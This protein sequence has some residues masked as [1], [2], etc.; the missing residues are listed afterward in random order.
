MVTTPEL[1]EMLVAS[2]APV[3]RLRPPILRAG[4]WS[5]SAAVA[6]GVLAALHGPRDD[7]AERLGQA[8]FVAEL[9]GPLLTA[10]SAAVAAFYLS[11]PDRSRLW[12]LLPIPALALWVAT[13]AHSCLANWIS[14][15][16]DGVRPGSTL[17]SL[18]T[19][20]IASLPPFAIFSVMLRHAALLYPTMLIVMGG[21]ASVG[22]A[23][24]ALSL[25]RELDGAG[26]VPLCPILRWLF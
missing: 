15:G 7:L 25:L 2:A 13:I 10:I 1:I 20:V 18:A 21:L 6:L 3:R 19:L 8:S 9:A 17:V 16:T 5:L 22:I 11:L 14:V 26:V 23:A 24:T 12:A 4:I